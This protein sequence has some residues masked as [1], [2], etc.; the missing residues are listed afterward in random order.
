MR[1]GVTPIEAL[2]AGKLQESKPKREG[3]RIM[4]EQKVQLL[5]QNTAIAAGEVAEKPVCSKGVCRNSLD[6]GR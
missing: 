6:A 3:V 5:D 2:N 1:C 4:N